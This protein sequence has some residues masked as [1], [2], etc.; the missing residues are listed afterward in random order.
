MLHSITIDQASC[1]FVVSSIDDQIYPLSESSDIGLRQH[2][3]DGN[4]FAGRTTGSQTFG[5]DQ[6]FG[7]PDLLR[8]IEYLTREVAQC[9]HIPITDGE[10]PKACT[11]QEG[12]IGRAKASCPDDKHMLRGQRDLPRSPH[13]RE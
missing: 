6:G 9:D 3:Y 2:H 1:G 11:S 8:R 13:L 10:L 5:C 12:E 4:H 7:L